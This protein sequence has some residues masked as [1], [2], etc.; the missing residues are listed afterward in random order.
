MKCPKCG[1]SQESGLECA[2]CGIVFAKV[3][4]PPAPPIPPVPGRSAAAPR[5]QAPAEPGV[6]FGAVVLT[7]LLTGLIVFAVVR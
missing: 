1:H 7:A 3:L 6:G 5:R 4:P 2:A